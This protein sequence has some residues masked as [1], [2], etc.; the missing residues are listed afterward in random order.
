MKRRIFITSLGAGAYEWSLSTPAQQ[1]S[2]PVIDYINAA[3]ET[4]TRYLTLALKQ[5]LWGERLRR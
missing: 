2:L 3:A 4:N 1:G 5:G